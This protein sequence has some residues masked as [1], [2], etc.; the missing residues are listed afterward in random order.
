[1]SNDIVK[2]DAPSANGL[3][4]LKPLAEA[5]VPVDT[6]Y[7][8]ISS[9]LSALS[10]TTVDG[11]STDTLGPDIQAQAN[12][13]LLPDTELAMLHSGAL[14]MSE[15]DVKAIAERRKRTTS[16]QYRKQQLQI[17]TKTLAEITGE[18]MRVAYR[19]VRYMTHVRGIQGGGVGIPLIMCMS[20]V[21]SQMNLYEMPMAYDPTVGRYNGLGAVRNLLA[22]IGES[23]YRYSYFLNGQY[24]K[25]QGMSILPPPLHD[26][27]YPINGKP[28]W[29]YR[30][31]KYTPADYEAIY[32]EPL[33]VYL[34]ICE[35][36][37][38][39]LGIG[40]EDIGEQ[41]AVAALLNP[42]I[43]RLAWPCRDEIELFE[44][45]VLLPYV[46]R[47]IADRSPD[48]TVDK[49]KEDMNLTH[50]EAFDLVE[51]YKT[52]SQQVNVFDPEK[53]RSVMINKLHRLADVCQESAMVTTQLNTHK[54]ILQT[55]GLTK[56]EEDDN[57]DRRDA[58][59]NA[60]EAQIIESNAEIQEQEQRQGSTGQTPGLKELKGLT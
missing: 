20:A 43:A 1:M 12:K 32:D 54:A 17:P 51:M 57:V 27:Y 37:V 53:E 45:A 13:G 14:P 16:L 59:E 56:H 5:I 33:A 9:T 42:K 41:A 26:G 3:Q 10:N 2:S 40:Q 48:S 6:M 4:T 24:Y 22:V 23:A 38:E 60:L 58:I 36:L 52:Y 7:A 29:E 8:T 55:L 34:N 15:D 31:H 11:E 50:A 39:I 21:S 46:G 44:E 19:L 18:R 47:L 25:A 30:R 35:L 49:L 28:L